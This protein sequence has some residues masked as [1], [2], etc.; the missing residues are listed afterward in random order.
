MTVVLLVILTSHE[1]SDHI[2]SNARV[3]LHHIICSNTWDDDFICCH[4][5][6]K[7]SQ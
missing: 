6:D 1:F 5:N 3:V 4:F 2:Q 7:D